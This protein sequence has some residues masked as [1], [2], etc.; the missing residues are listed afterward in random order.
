MDVASNAAVS[1]NSTA[2]R[3][4]KGATIPSYC[5]MKF[6]FFGWITIQ[7]IRAERLVKPIKSA[8]IRVVS[9]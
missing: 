4:K 5:P 1:E 9:L 8:R 6:L 3:L 7:V 2:G